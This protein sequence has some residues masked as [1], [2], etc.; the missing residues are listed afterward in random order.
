V[1]VT[2]LKV[3]KRI[4][5]IG[6]ALFFALP[7]WGQL[8][9]GQSGTRG[10]SS[11]AQESP[12][13]HLAA[14]RP[15]GQDAN[16]PLTPMQAV[17]YRLDLLEEDL[18]LLPQQD[19]AWRT[20]RDRVIKLAEDAQRSSRSAMGDTL[21]APQRLDRIGDIAR[22]RLTAIEDV[23]DAGKALYAMLTPGQQAVADRRMA[24]PVL[25]LIGVEPSA[26]NNRSLAAP[27]DP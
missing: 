27:K 18:R 20:Y 3:G 4:V 5:L 1:N 24:T 22:D 13:P 16:A 14:P 11:R 26:T 10:N 17:K 6:A 15:P 12:T 19:A 9:G 2:A 7:A 23:V 25:P 21:P 8:G